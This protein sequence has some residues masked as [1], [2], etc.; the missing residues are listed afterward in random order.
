MVNVLLLNA[1]DEPLA[2][3]S[4]KRAVGL[5]LADKVDLVRPAADRELH[6]A[7]RAIPVPSVIRLRYYVS[8]PH[9]TVAW[10][11]ANVLRRDHYTCQ[12]CGHRMTTAEA[13]IDHVV[14]QARCKKMNINANTWTNTVACCRK[15][16]KRKGDKS[17]EETG[18]KFYDH[19]FTPKRPR[20]NYIVFAL[21]SAP[22]EWRKY[23]RV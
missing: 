15:C 4:L 18:M 7:H 14:S 10:S 19:N 9:R 13:T 21:G 6:S 8:V 2:V 11:R 23:I 1:S 3:V 20:V 22:D 17:M 5:M 12:Y 16:Q